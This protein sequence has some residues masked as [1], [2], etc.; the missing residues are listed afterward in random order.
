MV[1]VSLRLLYY[2]YLQS[3]CIRNDWEAC[4]AEYWAAD[5]ARAVSLN[6]PELVAAAILEELLEWNAQ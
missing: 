5:R 3:G 4:K 2:Y 6:R 1:P